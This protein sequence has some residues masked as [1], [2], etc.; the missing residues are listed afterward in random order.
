MKW[1]LIR[2]QKDDMLFMYL[3]NVMGVIMIRLIS[4]TKA[5]RKITLI[6][7]VVLGKSKYKNS[8]KEN[9]MDESNLDDM[10]RS[11]PENVCWSRMLRSKKIRLPPVSDFHFLFELYSPESC[12]I[13]I[14]GTKISL[15]VAVFC[16]LHFI[17]GV[18][19]QLSYIFISDF[20]YKESVK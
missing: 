2:Q 15:H 5:N 11:I 14:N 13:H 17:N 16:Q 8:Q 6:F 20:L 7:I 10:L 9:V 1:T 18:I 4:H 12:K 19:I 3:R